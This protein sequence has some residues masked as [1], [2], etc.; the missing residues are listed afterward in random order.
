MFLVVLLTID[1]SVVLPCE[2]LPVFHEW[3]SAI[4]NL[5][6]KAIRFDV[7]EDE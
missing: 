1:I 5:L 7:N 6:L 3:F 2:T 4:V